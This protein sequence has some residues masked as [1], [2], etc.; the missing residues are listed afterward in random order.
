MRGEPEWVRFWQKVRFTD[1]C[2][3]W[4]A[5]NTGSGHGV[6]RKSTTE[7]V[8]AHRWAYENLVGP[9]PEGLT[10]D[11]LCRNR[12]CVLVDHLEPVSFK[13]NVRRGMS[14]AVVTS[15]TG[16]CQRGHAMVGRN[17]IERIDGGRQCR[18]CH[19]VVKRLY[20]QRRSLGGG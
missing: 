13:E 12:S 7:K 18:E 19:K 11:H 4:V 20:A 14:P 6:F 16:V 17:V 5:A 15:R 1:T 9:I 8:L 2:W 10:I 3:E